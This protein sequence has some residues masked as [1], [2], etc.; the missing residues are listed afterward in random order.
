MGQ[1]SM[2][3]CWRLGLV[4]VLAMGGAISAFSGNCA[5]AQITPDNTLG[6]ESSRVTPNVEVK[7]SPANLIEG[8]AARGANLFHSFS[9]FNVGELQRV[10]FSNPAAT[11]NILSRVTGNNLSNILG[12]SQQSTREISMA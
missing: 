9:E 6:A 2:I 8:G 3:W 7:G 4:S 10:Y 5:L 12:R 11:E 1:G